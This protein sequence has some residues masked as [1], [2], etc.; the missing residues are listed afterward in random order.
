MLKKDQFAR[1]FGVGAIIVSIAFTLG[2]F[3]SEGV[4]RLPFDPYAWGI[5]FQIVIYSFGIAYRQ[6]ALLLKS[7]EE[8]LHA[9]KTYAEMLRIKEINEVKTL[10]YT[11]ISHEFRTPLTLIAGPLDKAHKSSDPDSDEVTI[12]KSSFGIINRNTHRLQHLI[13]QLL[14]LSK[15]ESGQI[16]LNLMQGGLVDFIKSIT[17]SFESIAE[18]KN[19]SLNT[20]FPK[21][22]QQ[23]FYDKD[24]LEKIIS[25]L[26]SNAFKYTP[27][28]GVVTLTL[29]LTDSHYILEVSDTGKGMSKEEMKRIFERFYRVEGTEEKGT[30]IGLALAKEMVDLQNG[31]ISVS[32]LKDQGTTFKVRIP[33]TLEFLPEHISFFTKNKVTVPT[34]AQE[35]NGHVI[36]G[37]TYNTDLPPIDGNKNLPVLLLVEDNPDL[38]IYISD[39]L[40]GHY[41]IVIAEDGLK[42]ERMG[43][44]HIPDIILTDIMMPK[45]DGYQLCNSL[46]SNPKTS[47]I[48]IV[49]LT[50]KGGQENRIEGLTQ[51]ADAY[52]TKPFNAEELLLLVKNLIQTRVK[53]W[54]HFNSLNLSIVNDIDLVSIED[55]FL[56]SVLSVIR[57]NLDNESLSVEDLAKEVG[58]SRAQLHRKLKALCDKS[59][60]QLIV[61][62]RLNE[63]MVMLE[64]KIGSVSEVAYSVGYSNLSYFTKRFKEK[65]NVLPSRV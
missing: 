51:G 38:R 43:I 58:F 36:N 7:Q 60:N 50:A 12:S 28:G 2:G 13:D 42:G 46:K 18:S 47:H 6:R 55:K 56:Q 54:E 29:D 65:F 41:K 30:G 31:Q 11:N 10:F 9:Q 62:I 26:L 52:I 61:E 45:K 39:I 44:E 35:I 37:E 25:N 49:M 20:S 22:L 5:F 17:F 15:I 34:L 8:K 27:E 57:N 59:P 24:K 3:W 33:Y 23:A 48:P 1:Y 19:I 4:I 32:S 40:K 21:A 16:H 64:K 53:M 63:A 14:E